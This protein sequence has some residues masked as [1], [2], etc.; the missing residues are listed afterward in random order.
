M[1][2]ERRAEDRATEHGPSAANGHELAIDRVPGS[3][4][5]ADAD[6]SCDFLNQ[7]W[8]EYAGMTLAEAKGTGY[9]AAV[10]PDDKEAMNAF[11]AGFVASGQGAETE[12]RLRRFDGVYRWF[13]IRAMP[14]KDRSGRVI[15]WYGTTTDIEDRK[16]AETLL[17]GEKRLLE[18]IATGSPLEATLDA[19]CRLVEAAAPDC[20]STVILVDVR[21]KRCWPAA[22]PT[23]PPSYV[24]LLHAQV[25]LT[26]GPCAA[27]AITQERVAVPDWETEQRWPALRG[28]VLQYGL[29]AS[30]SWPI[31]STRGTALGM[32]T[33]Y[34]R[35]PGTPGV[36]HESLIAQLTHI[37]SI[38]IERARSEE[39]LRQSEEE[40]SEA[41]RLSHA[42]SFRWRP[43]V[44]T[45]S[46]SAE[47]TGIFG[48]DPARRPSRKL[49]RKRLHP[50]DRELVLSRAR[51]VEREGAV[52]DL[53]HRLLLP[54]GTVRH[55]HSVARTLRTPAGE[56]EV[57]GVVRDVTERKRAEDALHKMQTE[58]AHVARVS[59]LGAIAASIAHEVN[60]PLG[61][62]AVS[63][64]ACHDWLERDR[65]DLAE[66]REAAARVVGYAKRAA[67]VI[68]RLRAL[69]KKEAG[70]EPVSLNEAITD[71][72]ALARREMQR[73]RVSLHVDLADGLPPVRGDR[74]QVQQVVLNLILNAAEAMSGIEDRPREL[75]I[76]SRVV[77]DGEVQVTV[78]DTGPG[79][80]PQSAERVFEPFYTTKSGGMGMGLSISRSIIEN[81]GGKIW[82]EPNAAHG[83][84]FRFA[85][86]CRP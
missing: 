37:A 47:L 48:I 69:F 56:L 49:L 28:V 31:M 72:L 2:F 15:K 8:L 82:T 85:I 61:A 62:I 10:H 17:A 7:R 30:W 3:L 74:V 60:Q 11:C 57:F 64:E 33:L 70:S 63:A 81:H 24:R 39:V 75:A 42:G 21:C 22:A 65:P 46:W 67:E 1:S 34:S 52:V 27:A 84:T 9:R 32:F 44:R 83:A 45:L 41:Q 36:Q 68:T 53:E 38:A 80:D 51:E 76:S 18:M 59:A 78:Q 6:G 58:F 25:E 40:K 26:A 77:P 66:A 86:P 14:H 12:T 55:V 20:S 4:W 71:V 73:A 29:R 79:L 43:A 23:M 35:Q 13:L 5:T 19:V 16:R 50:E 54:D